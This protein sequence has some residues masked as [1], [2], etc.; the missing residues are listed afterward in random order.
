MDSIRSIRDIGK[1]EKFRE[2]V[3]KST[4]VDELYKHLIKVMSTG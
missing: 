3:K 2:L 1:L 4:T